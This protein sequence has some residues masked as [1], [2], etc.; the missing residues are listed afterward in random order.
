M[1]AGQTWSDLRQ[2]LRAD[3]AR[4][5]QYFEDEVGREVRIGFLHQAMLC[6]RLH[7]YAHYFD[8]R[9]HR[10]IA[11][12]FWQLNCL[13]TGADISPPSELGPGLVIPSPAAVA[14][15]G[16]VGR[17]L[18]IKALSGIGAEVG[19]RE[20]IGAGPGLP[21]IGD[22]VTIEVQSGILGPVRVGNR[23]TIGPAAHVVSDVPEGSIVQGVRPHVIRQGESH[24][25]TP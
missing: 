20:D 18:T 11:R 17:N 12:F 25:P 24:A 10:Y 1:A 3:R 6:V 2:T 23:V 8:S 9:G 5:K 19:R 7:R 4:L 16:K 21:V 14:I 13:L 15:S 22:D